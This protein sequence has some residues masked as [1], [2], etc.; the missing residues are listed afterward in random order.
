MPQKHAHSNGIY[1]KTTFSGKKPTFVIT[2]LKSV[3]T[4]LH[5]PPNLYQ[6]TC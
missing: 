1:W 4:N 3:I 6:K 5:S 2:A